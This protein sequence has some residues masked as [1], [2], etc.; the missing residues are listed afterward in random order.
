MPGAW[1]AGTARPDRSTDLSANER[2]SDYVH[3]TAFFLEVREWKASTFLP[4]LCLFLRSV[5]H[6]SPAFS[7]VSR[8]VIRIQPWGALALGL[9]NSRAPALGSVGKSAQGPVPGRCPLGRTP[10]SAPPT[11]GQA[12]RTPRGQ[13]GPVRRAISSGLPYPLFKECGIGNH[14]CREGVTGA[15]PHSRLCS[16]FLLLRGQTRMLVRVS[17]AVEG[18]AAH[19]LQPKNLTQCWV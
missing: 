15:E 14:R 13:R 16:R 10:C 9:E 18:N 6:L 5:T 12:C 11:A 2:V 4:F 3:I 19:F 8:W 1:G 17:G 7:S